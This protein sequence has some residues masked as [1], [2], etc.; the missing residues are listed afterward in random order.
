MIQF[1]SHS[2]GHFESKLRVQFETGETLY[3]DVKCQCS[4]LK[5]S[6]NP[7]RLEFGNVSMGMSGRVKFD[8]LN[9]SDRCVEFSWVKYAHLSKDLEEI[10]RLEDSSDK[11]KVHD[12]LLS[13]VFRYREILTHECHEFS[14]DRLSGDE[15]STLHTSVNTLFAF[16]NEVFEIEPMVCTYLSMKLSGDELS[17]LH[18]SVN[19]L[20]AFSNE[21]FEI[22]PM[23]CTYLS[24]KL[25][26]DELS[27]LHTS[28]NTL[29]AFSNEVFE[30][31]PMVCT[32][33]SMKLSGDELSTLHTSVNTLF[34]FSNEVFEIEPMVC[35][36]LSMKLSGDELSTLHTSVNTLFAFSNEVFE[37]EPMVCTYLSMKLSG[38]ELSTLHTSVNTL[39][40]FSNEVFE[41]EPMVCTYLSMKLSGDEL[42]TLHTSVNTLFAFSNEVFEI[43]PMVCTYLS[44]KLSGDELS[45]LHTSVNTLFAFSNE[46]FEIE[47]MTG[48]VYSHSSTPI[49]AT[50]RPSSPVSFE[51]KAFCELTGLDTRL[52]LTVQGCGTGPKFTLSSTKIILDPICVC[53]PISF[54]I[55]VTNVSDIPGHIHFKSQRLVFGGELSCQPHNALLCPRTA[56]LFRL[57]FQS[58]FVGKFTE[59]VC[60][61][62]VESNEELRFVLSNMMVADRNTRVI[63]PF[64]PP[65][66]RAVR[67]RCYR[68]YYGTHYDREWP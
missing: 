58:N 28:V 66:G 13:N 17:T 31:E 3:S 62:V 15:M 6:L 20:F 39:F 10:K 12:H 45:T 51:M 22:E 27:T 56:N 25:S 54:E 61:H 35:T 11:I 59:Y 65:G 49:T 4:N 1:M 2:V 40:A 64:E 38:D 21:V 55:Y 57:V 16:S 36:Y 26:G 46:V 30:I 68:S 24:M 48:S 5:L 9:H 37:I 50:F 47:P 14:N 52:G 67:I 63:Y 8:I 34:A 60:F 41:I 7:S 19:T 42:S 23:V 29:F 33:L 43:E 44:M 53:S 18:T 32:Y